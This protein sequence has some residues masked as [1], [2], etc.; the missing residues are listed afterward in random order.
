MSHRI[1]KTLFYQPFLHTYLYNPPTQLACPGPIPPLLI[2]RL[3]GGQRSLGVVGRGQR[4]P[5][6]YL[7]FAGGG[8]SESALRSVLSGV[9]AALTSL[10]L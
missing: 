6:A 5:E 10:H 2:A 7:G 8:C 9:T 1:L 4:P 3:S